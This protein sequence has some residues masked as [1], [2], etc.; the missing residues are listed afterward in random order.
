MLCYEVL[1]CT[2]GLVHAQSENEVMSIVWLV[3]PR[4]VRYMTTNSPIQVLLIKS[5]NS[6]TLK[7]F[8]GYA[9]CDVFFLQLNGFDYF[10]SEN[11]FQVKCCKTIL[12]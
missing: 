11:Y 6:N 4:D 9:Y 10:L 3:P 2:L 8:S 1:C 12:C 7:F 5:H